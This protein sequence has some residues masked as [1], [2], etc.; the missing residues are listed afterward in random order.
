MLNNR[1]K[2]LRQERKMTQEEVAQQLCVS[3]QTVSKWER[4]LLSPDISLLPKIAMLF[5]CSIDYLFEMDI[6]RESSH[7]EEFINLIRKLSREK[8][9]E[10]IFQ[11][12]LREIER[13]PDDYV[14][15][16]EL[17]RFV[18][19]KKMVDD[20]YI[21]KLLTLAD[22]AERHC[23]DDDIKA[24]IYRMMLQVC[25]LST[26]EQIREKSDY[27]YHKLPTIRYSREIMVKFA[28]KNEEE[29]RQQVKRNILYTI[30]LAE[31]SIRQLITP[32]STLENRLFYYQKAAALYETV[33]DDKYAGFYDAPLLFDYREIM[34]CLIQ[35]EKAEMAETYLSAFFKILERHLS[36][37]DRKIKSEFV[38]ETAPPRTTA[39]ETI[40]FKLLKNMLQD[41]IL[42]HFK[43]R[44]LDMLTR[45]SSVFSK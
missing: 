41:P 21:Q 11:A 6:F 16:P 38:C 10:E 44:I 20:T 4:G 8:K 40:C 2:T 34:R 19:R 32:E 9:E 33:L 30:D 27:F 17:M 25:S 42:E 39:V 15:Y 3:S 35:M 13:Y 45:Y 24:E 37:A 22:Y 29:Y 7:H 43:S 14:N 12:F 28:A 1:L 26:N 18:L 5:D 36:K 31:C 23:L